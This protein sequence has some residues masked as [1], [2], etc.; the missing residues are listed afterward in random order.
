MRSVVDTAANRLSVD[1]ALIFTL[2]S[3]CIYDLLKWWVISL[4]L[5]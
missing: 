3:N 5:Q 1:V 4:F 2:I